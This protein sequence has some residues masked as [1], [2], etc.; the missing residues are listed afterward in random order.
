M[1]KLLRGLIDAS[2]KASYGKVKDENTPTSPPYLKSKSFR[3]E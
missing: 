2:R 3:E 1:T